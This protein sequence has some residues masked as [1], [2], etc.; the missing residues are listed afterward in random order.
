MKV[1]VIGDIHGD[2]IWKDIVKKETPDE[3]VFL[4]DYFD[5]FYLTFDQQYYNFK[6]IVDYKI[7]NPKVTLLLGNHDF[8]YISPN[9]QYSGYQRRYANHIGGILKTFVDDGILSGCF[10]HKNYLLTHAGVSNTWCNNWDIRKSHLDID[11]NTAL[12][13]EKRNDIFR[14]QGTNVYGD[15]ITQGPLW[16]RENSLIKDGIRNY[17]Q[18]VG[19]THRDKVHQIADSFITIVDALPNQ[20]VTIEDDFI[21]IKT[22]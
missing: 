20:Y 10:I 19:H 13:S 18:V 6:E 22:V 7:S 9:E 1:L 11:I 15:D 4:G 2:N 21:V 14:F 8:H 16:I 17:H 5:S 12:L 3:T